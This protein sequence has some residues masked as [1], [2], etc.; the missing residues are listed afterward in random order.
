MPAG[1]KLVERVAQEL[2]LGQRKRSTQITKAISD[3]TSRA[4]RYAIKTLEKQG[5]AVREGHVVMGIAPESAAPVH[6]AETV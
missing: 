6:Q 4:V 1:E 2:G 5:R 3:K